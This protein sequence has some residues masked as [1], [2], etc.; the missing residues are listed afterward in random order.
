L[1]TSDDS[2][3]RRAAWEAAK[4]VGAEVAD[5]VRE[6]VA[7]R[8]EGARTLGYR[9]HFELALATGELDEAR[10]FATLDEVDRATAAPFAEWKA[11]LDVRSAERFGVSVNELRPWHYDDPFFQDPPA[12]GA[13]SLDELFADVDV[14]ALTLRTYDAI[15]LDLRPVLAGSDLYAREGKSQ[16]AFCIDIDR[17]G[18]VRVLCNVEANERWM[19]TMLHEFGHASYDV[20][21]DR[22]LPWL[23]RSASHALTTEGVAMLMGRFARDPE[24]LVFSGVTGTGDIDELRAG[25]AAAKRANLLVFARW[26]LV[27]TH[28]ERGLYAD[29]DADHETRWWDLVERFQLVRGPEPL[30]GR[31]AWASKVHLTVAPVYYQNYLYGELF[32]SQL[33]AAITARTGGLVGQ[34]DAGRFL[35]DAVFSP[36]TAR[37]WDHLVEDATGAPLSVDAFARQLA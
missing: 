4:Q 14:E 8:N 31:A 21:V 5:Q 34:P 23:L 18:D 19:D 9:D 25:L 1:R 6:L 7:V 29:P 10:L 12:R 36:G 32:A 35:G 17:E 2:S 22:E 11:A 37:R 33:D 20:G 16:H 3:E 24:W 15:G 26:V 30:A 27:M 13:I 28:F